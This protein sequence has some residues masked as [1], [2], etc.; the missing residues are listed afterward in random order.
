MPPSWVPALAISRER[1][2]MRCPKGAGR[3]QF[4]QCR[5]EIFAR[6]GECARWDGLA[7]RYTLYEVGG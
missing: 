2:D 3:T 1:L 7:E 5:R 4:R 6:F